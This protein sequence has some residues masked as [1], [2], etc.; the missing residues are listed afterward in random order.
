[1]P[2]PSEEGD[3][4]CHVPTAGL[5]VRSVDGEVEILNSGSQISN[6][7]LR[8]GA[9]KWSKTAYRTGVDF[10]LARPNPTNWSPDSALTL[11]IHDGRVFGRHSTVTVE[12]ADDHVRYVYNL[13][14][15]PGQT[16]CS[17]DTGVWWNAGWI[18]QVHAFE[19]RQPG[20]LRVGG[21]ALSSSQPDT[22]KTDE[23]DGLLSVWSND[24]G[25]IL[26][27]LSGFAGHDWEQRLDDSVLRTHLRRPFHATAVAHTTPNGCA[28][29][30]TGVLVA[31]AWTGTDRDQAQAW[32][33]HASSPGRLELQHPSLGN[34]SIDHELIPQIS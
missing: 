32:S 21:Y 16:N 8:Y 24:Q 31:L 17:V 4:V 1:M 26:Q 28:S 22:L 19:N 18:L 29:G 5:T 13:G 7:N 10:T 30:E 12:M 34:W 6:V 2:L 23:S 9:W 20:V 33:I 15:K 3:H 11:K 25:S 14:F 27:P